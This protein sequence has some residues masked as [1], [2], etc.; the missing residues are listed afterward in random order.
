MHLRLI[1]GDGGSVERTCQHIEI[2]EMDIGI[3]V[4]LVPGPTW[5]L[6][7]DGTDVYVMTDLAKVINHLV[8]PPK[9]K[10]AK[11]FRS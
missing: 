5:R 2:T 4:H 3:E 11:E 6:P 9:P 8:W 10:S 7:A 1:K